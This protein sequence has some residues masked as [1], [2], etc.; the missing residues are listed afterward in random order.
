[1]YPIASVPRTNIQYKVMFSDNINLRSWWQAK[2]HARTQPQIQLQFYLF[3]SISRH[4]DVRTILY[5]RKLRRDYS[6]NRGTAL[7]MVYHEIHRD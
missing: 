1:M 3:V 4:T 6:Q 2:L 7:A 5:I